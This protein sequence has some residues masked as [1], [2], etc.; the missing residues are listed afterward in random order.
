MID[1][2]SHA[3]NLSRCETKVEYCYELGKLTTITVA[4][5]HLLFFTHVICF[6]TGLPSYAFRVRNLLTP[7][8]N[9]MKYLDNKKN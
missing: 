5:P 7:F 9:T 8:A 3:H 4:I 1:H 2:R 6:Y